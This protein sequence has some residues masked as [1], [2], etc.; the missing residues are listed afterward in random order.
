VLDPRSSFAAH[1]CPGAALTLRTDSGELV[2]AGFAPQ[3]E[4]LEGYV[5][6]DWNA[7]LHPRRRRTLRRSRAQ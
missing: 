3:D 5:V 7:L 6:L 2:A 1:S 4:D